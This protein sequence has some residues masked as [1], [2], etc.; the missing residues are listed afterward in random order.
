MI[1]IADGEMNQLPNLIDWHQALFYAHSK[2]S[3]ALSQ[4]NPT[5]PTRPRGRVELEL[6]GKS[7]T[8]PLA[9]F[10]FIPEVFF[11]SPGCFFSNIPGETPRISEPEVNEM[12]S[13]LIVGVCTFFLYV[14]YTRSDSFISEKDVTAEK[15][16]WSL[17]LSLL[18]GVSPRQ[19][20]TYYILV[21]VHSYSHTCASWLPVL[22]S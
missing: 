18:W 20:V 17:S 4:Y 3:L 6:G 16:S 13:M 12:T 5:R 14:P 1:V 11:Y 2:L 21:L 19:S 22:Q 8:E 15:K 7:E 9:C 10:H